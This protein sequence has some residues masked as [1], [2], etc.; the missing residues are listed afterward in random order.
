MKSVANGR[1]EQH[2]PLETFTETPV[3][4]AV[5]GV[6][7]GLKFHSIQSLPTLVHGYSLQEFCDRYG[8]YGSLR[9]STRGLR[10]LVRGKRDRCRSAT[11][12]NNTVIFWSSTS[13]F[14]VEFDVSV[15]RL[16]IRQSTWAFYLVAYLSHRELAHSPPEGQR[17]QS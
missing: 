15:A 7:K 8:S 1:E 9:R 14:L 13:A 12:G 5:K 3:E 4:F 6:R 2:L 16:A 10:L 11:F 17:C